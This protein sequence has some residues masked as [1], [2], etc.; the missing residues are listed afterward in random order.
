MTRRL[1]PRTMAGQF[2]ALLL[3][4]LLITQLAGILL[5]RLNAQMLNPV[6]RDQVLDRM[7]IAWRLLQQAPPARS[8]G[9]RAVGPRGSAR[10]PRPR[11][12][13]PPARST[14]P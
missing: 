7:V 10:T 2:T 5:L 11:A 6:S 1:W 4:G 9:A 12:R 3:A 13:R 14:W 8:P